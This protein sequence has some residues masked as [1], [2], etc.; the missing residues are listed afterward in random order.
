VRH[1]LFGL[2][3]VFAC[4]GLGPSLRWTVDFVTHGRKTLVP[5]YANLERLP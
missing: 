2:G 3:E 5:A 4:E 1:P